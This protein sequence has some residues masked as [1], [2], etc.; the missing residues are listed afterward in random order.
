MKEDKK[1]LRYIT[2]GIVAMNFCWREQEEKHQ[3]RNI[4]CKISKIRIKQNDYVL[5][6]AAPE[7]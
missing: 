3:Q 4:S 1:P 5:P 7:C 2:K 6:L